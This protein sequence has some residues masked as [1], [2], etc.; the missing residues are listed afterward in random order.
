MDSDSDSN[1]SQLSD[2]SESNSPSQSSSSPHG[3]K[4][5][6]RKTSST[7]TSSGSTTQQHHPR[8]FG[9]K[10]KSRNSTSP[11]ERLGIPPLVTTPI[12]EESENSDVSTPRS[13]HS[14]GTLTAAT[15][16][17]NKTHKRSQTRNNLNEMENVNRL[18]R[19]KSSGNSKH[20][21]N[22][23]SYKSSHNI[24]KSHKKNETNNKHKNSRKRRRH[25][26]QI[27]SSNRHSFA[28]K[29]SSSMM[30]LRNVESPRL[31]VVK[32]KNIREIERG[33]LIKT[34]SNDNAIVNGV[35]VAANT[36]EI[37]LRR[38][39]NE[40]NNNS[41]IQDKQYT[42]IGFDQIKHVVRSFGGPLDNLTK[43]SKGLVKLY[44][45]LRL[46]LYVCVCLFVFVFALFA[47]T[48]FYNILCLCVC[49]LVCYSFFCNI[50]ALIAKNVCIFLLF[51]NNCLWFLFAFDNKEKTFFAYYYLFDRNK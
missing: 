12:I 25:S 27:G 1:A 22:K 35:N 40:K 23:R 49:L 18:H 44:F 8:D 37:S 38:N 4:S 26:G 6:H 31:S 36:I 17:K 51:C 16:S 21:T 20:K 29:S 13:H 11:A 50:L 34:I 10:N 47:F 45:I 15:G 19:T 14:S 33:D 24:S 41:G 5:K 2:V 7:A 9:Y 30:R 28:S 32:V 3:K 39:R 43:A 42:T 48:F 46:R